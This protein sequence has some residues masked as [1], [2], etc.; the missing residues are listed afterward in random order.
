[1]IAFIAAAGFALSTT[2]AIQTC[3]SD[4][5]LDAASVTERG[6]MYSERR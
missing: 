3:A 6:R 1:M 5:L 2:T 4:R